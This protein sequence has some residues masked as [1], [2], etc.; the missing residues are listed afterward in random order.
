MKLF[1]FITGVLW[2][3]VDFTTMD[4]MPVFFYS[5]S[6]RL[7]VSQQW[8]LCHNQCAVKKNEKL[9]QGKCCEKMCQFFSQHTGYEMKQAS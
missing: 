9:V 1:H 6:S 8:T 4:F 3:I 7:L 2:Q 5:Y